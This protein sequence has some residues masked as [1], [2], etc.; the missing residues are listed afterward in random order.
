MRRAVTLNNN[1]EAVLRGVATCGLVLLK[2]LMI[3]TV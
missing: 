3:Y 2:N 1:E